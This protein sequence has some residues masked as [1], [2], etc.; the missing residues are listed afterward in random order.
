MVRSSNGWSASTVEDADKVLFGRLRDVAAFHIELIALVNG[1]SPPINE[2]EFEPE[3]MA[4]KSRR[5]TQ[6]CAC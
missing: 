1:A 5:A 3:P 6:A 4:K 2:R